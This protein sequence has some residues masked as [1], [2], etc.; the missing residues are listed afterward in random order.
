MTTSDRLAVALWEADRHART[1]AEAL[2]DWDSDP[3]PDWPALD[4]DRE[5]VRLIDQ[6]LFRFIKLQDSLG[7]RLVP[8]T[9]AALSEPYEDW[10]MRDR[11]NRLEKLGYLQVDSWLAWREVRNRLAHEYP[12]RPELRFA[13]LLAAIEAARELRAMWERWSA[14]LAYEGLTASAAQPHEPRP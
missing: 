11:L 7:E 12:D 6:L 3:A 13:A 1:L 9:L 14:R 4:A 10:P 5:K 8:A 2:G